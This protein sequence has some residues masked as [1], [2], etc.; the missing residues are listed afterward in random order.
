MMGPTW[1]Q[2]QNQS[3]QRNAVDQQQ[4]MKDLYGDPRS[5]TGDMLSMFQNYQLQQQDP[6]AFNR[7]NFQSWNPFGSFAPS[8][9]KNMY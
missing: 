2:V 5:F 9:N 4:Q 6:Q 1:G 7:Q 3:T 8:N